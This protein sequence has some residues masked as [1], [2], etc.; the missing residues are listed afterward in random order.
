M[1]V[2]T[3]KW[4]PALL[5]VIAGLMTGCDNSSRTSGTQTPAAAKNDPHAA[6]Q[7]EM[8]K[9]TM[10]FSNVV[11]VRLKKD[12]KRMEVTSIM[13]LVVAETQVSGQPAKT[14][15]RVNQAGDGLVM[16]SRD[17]LKGASFRIEIK[18]DALEKK[19]AFTFPVLQ[20]DGRLLENRFELEK[21]IIP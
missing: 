16:F 4:V 6:E 2:S 9:A 5:I 13:P 17:L 11:V 12:D 21:I 10:D 8:E 7:A 14:V 20:K 15:F 1:S 3:T 18:F 19:K